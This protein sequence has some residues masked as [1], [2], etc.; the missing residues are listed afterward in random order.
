VKENLTMDAELKRLIRERYPFPI[1]HAH[2]R[3]LACL[4]ED[5]QKLKCLIQTAETVLQLLALVVLAQVHRDLER[6]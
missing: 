2:K 6:H 3:T 4:D 5:V 1:A